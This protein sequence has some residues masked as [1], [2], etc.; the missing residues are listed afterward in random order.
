MAKFDFTSL[1]GS[2]IMRRTPVNN[3]TSYKTIT[4]RSFSLVNALDRIRL[5]ESGSFYTSLLLT[6]FGTID[7]IAPTSLE[8]AEIMLLNL[9]AG[10]SPIIPTNFSARSTNWG[11]IVDGATFQT[12][13]NQYGDNLLVEDFTLTDGVLS[14]NISGSG[15]IQLYNKNITEI[16]KCDVS[17]CQNLA[18]DGNLITTISETVVLP[19]GLTRIGLSSNRV[20]NMVGFKNV[21][22]INLSMS[23]VLTANLFKTQSYIDSEP[24]ATA[25]PNGLATI[26]M[27]G[28]PNSANGTNFRNILQAKGYSVTF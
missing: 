4:F 7:G 27:G 11:V 25:Q 26:Q 20:V 1:N 22:S 23:L 6:D 19:S 12:A 9:I 5:Y 2:I 24:W 14:C 8:N 16:I 17:A 28:N 15:A 10:I 18:L 21:F 3:D 13:L